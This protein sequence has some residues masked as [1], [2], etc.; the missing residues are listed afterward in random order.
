MSYLGTSIRG[1]FW[2]IDVSYYPDI[3]SVDEW[4]KFIDAIIMFA[5]E[6]LN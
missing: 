4:K 2:N 1:C 6:E 5:N 3:S